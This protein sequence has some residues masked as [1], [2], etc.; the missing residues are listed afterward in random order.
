[1]WPERIPLPTLLAVLSLS[2]LPARSNGQQLSRLP[3]FGTLS[4]T[5]NQEIDPRLGIAE[6]DSVKKIKKTYWMEGG[7]VAGA[8]LGILTAA[9]VGGLCAD[10]DSGGE[11]PCWDNT[12]L[13]GV[14]GFG[15]GF[16]VG[17]LIGGQFNKAEQPDS[18]ASKE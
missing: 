4:A 10:S 16:S 1:M 9:L 3:D 6:P 18:T 11:G 13:G 17:A 7:L 12:L 15:V 5:L 2:V 8:G 14:I